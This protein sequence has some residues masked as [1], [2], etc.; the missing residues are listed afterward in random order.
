VTKKIL[1]LSAYD[2][3]SHRHWRTQL[4]KMFPDY[5]WTQLTLPAR[6]F[7]WRIRGNSLSW[8]FGES[9]FLQDDYDLLI[10]TSMVDLSS[11]RGFIPKLAT[12]PTLVYFHENQFA[13]PMNIN[14][15]N[16]VEHQLVPIYSAL[17]ADKI[18]FNSDYNRHTFL[19]GAHS[20]FMKL[21]DFVPDNLSNRLE[22]GTVIP[23]PVDVPGN[24]QDQQQHPEDYLSVVWNHR[25]EYD[26]GPGLLLEIIRQVCAA[27]L[28]IIFHI[29]GEQFRQ[30]PAEFDQIQ[31]LLETHSEH[32]GV[33]AGHFGFIESKQQYFDCLQESDVVLSTT[34]HEFQGVAMQ[35]A[36]LSGCTPLAPDRLAY[37]EYLEPQFLFP[38]AQSTEEEALAVLESLKA[39]LELRTSGIELPQADIEHYRREHLQSQYA[40]LIESLVGGELIGGR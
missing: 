2:T 19:A 38:S 16:N 36:I 9:A 3:G 12:L 7:S 39:W 21:P 30:R 28:P 33:A 27:Q 24:K 6:H 35:E 40:T 25:W 26:K 32:I 10:A 29:L 1:L 11:L 22:L 37:P 15:N 34:L 18:C 5:A 17:C 20:L 23:V 4:E 8:G 14:K 13:Y 31:R